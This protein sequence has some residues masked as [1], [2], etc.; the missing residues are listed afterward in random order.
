MN[1]KISLGAAIAFMLIVASITFCITTIVSMNRFNRMVLNVK[2][3][4]ETYKKL[5]EIDRNGRQYFVGP[6]NEELLNNE[7][8]A[9]YVRGLGDKYSTY[10]SKAEYEQ[11]V[12]ELSGRMVQI[13]IS[14]QKDPTGYFVITEVAADSPAYLAGLM[15][16]DVLI[17]LNSTDLKNMSLADAQWA[18]KGEAGTKLTL[19]YRRDGVDTVKDITRKLLDTQYVQLQMLD[20]NAYICINTFNEKTADQFKSAVNDAVQQGASALILDLRNNNSDS[21]EAALDMLDTLLPDGALGNLVDKTGQKASLGNSDRYEINLPIATLVNGKTGNAAEY[22]VTTLRD[23]G[24]TNVIGTVTMGKCIKQELI[25]LA[26]GSA[27]CVTTH[28]VLPPS[29]NAIH[30]VGVKPDYEV[31]LTAEQEQN[32]A[33]EDPQLQKAQEVVNAKNS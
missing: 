32:L 27:I 12:L 28:Y 3:R 22:F 18:L 29:G 25:Q 10:L 11:R 5:S 16:G 23:F 13:G 24:R 7:I 6:I 31:K 15:V 17:D 33:N 26:D 30:G 8:S 2:E 9:G 1:K 19:T 21:I 20:K 4:E 14:I